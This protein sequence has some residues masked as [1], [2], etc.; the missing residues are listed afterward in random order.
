MA[1]RLLNLTRDKEWSSVV[2]SCAE[3]G[4]LECA[5]VEES[6]SAMKAII[7]KAADVAVVD[8][9]SPDLGGL[10][11][12]QVLRQ[13]DEGRTAAVILASRRKS[14]EDVAAA[15]ELGADDY[16][17]KSCDSVELLARTRAVLRRHFERSAVWAGREMSIGQVTLDPA[18]HLCWVRNNL[19]EL[20]PREFEL[21]EI[22]MKKAG[23]V[24]SRPYLLETIWGMSRL[25]N[26]RSID[27][28]VS[29]L[30]KA[31]GPRAGKWIET[32]ERYGYRFKDPAQMAR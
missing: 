4:Q 29:R 31:L 6:A 30:R 1:Y 24:L 9:D 12:L 22:L 19:V 23:R 25:A 16:V 8:L 20:N 10:S 14:D 18:R 21:L 17:L 3:A 26:T 28:A 32:I 5:L 2:T 11:W 15:F 27:V 7:Q 13:T